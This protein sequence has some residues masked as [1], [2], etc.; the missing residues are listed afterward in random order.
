MT[1]AKRKQVKVLLLDVDG[2]LTGGEIVYTDA[3]TETKSFNVKDGL[4][5]KLL[6]D[7]GVTVGIITGR[8]SNA[9]L[10]RCADLGI[11]LIY[12]GI[13]NK[14]AILDTV[15]KQIGVNA[16]EIAFAGDDLP[17]IPLLKKVGLAVAVADAHD[18]VKQIA[19]WVTEKNGGQGAVREICEAILAAK[20]L[21]E[22]CI[23]CRESTD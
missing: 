6:M 2:V 21:L 10:H 13:Q 3:G 23:A 22:N 16:D 4:G 7:A 1:T 5:I 12:D 20:G 8:R 15:V 9:L 18:A 17:D 19:D 14:G 11:N